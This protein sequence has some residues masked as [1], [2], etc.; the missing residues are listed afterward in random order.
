MNIPHLLLQFD[1]V[2]WQHYHSL[3]SRSY[4]DDPSSSTA[5]QHASLKCGLI[6][7]LVCSCRKY[8]VLSCC[9]TGLTFHQAAQPYSYTFDPS[10]ATL[11]QLSDDPYL[12]FL[13]EATMA[14]V[15]AEGA[16]T[17]EVLRIAS[18]LAP[19]SLEGFYPPFHWF[20]QQMHDLAESIDP[21]V[22]PVGAREAYFHA[23]TYNRNSV[24]TLLG[25]VNDP[26]LYDV[27]PPMQDEFAKA[28]ALLK[29]APGLPL[30]I[31]ATNSSIGAFEIPAYFFKASA[32]NSSLPTFI[33][34]TGYDGPMQDLYHFSCSEIL[35]RGVNC[36]T[37][38]GP[39]QA[40]P[41]R[42]GHPF[43][44]D[45]WSVV[46]PIVDYLHTRPDV[47]TDKIVLLGDSFGGLLAPL[48]ASKEH[49]LSAMVLLDGY[50]NFRQSLIEQFPDQLITLYNQSK[51]AE[52]N[53]TVLE[54]LASPDVPTSLKY[55]WEYTFWSLMSE[56]PY[57]AWTR[58]GDF[59][60]GP[61]TATEI[62]DLPVFVAKGQVSYSPLLSFLS[63]LLSG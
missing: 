58:L 62:G 3:H 36:L 26:R 48:A 34:G 9:S 7:G 13:L 38:E 37:Y 15:I 45:W 6:R 61:A 47:D 57:R 12:A 24:I 10:N 51:A 49:R 25:N 30:N 20:A 23:S 55:L 17:A 43:I 53:H 63:P 2:S 50:P 28:I 5:T 8:R 33:V 44:T 56:D 54:A 16:S 19:G 27:W 46:T 42:A 1:S 41:R 40:T 39:G 29:P 11:Y 59:S 60:W 21:N 22:D 52:F 31:T 18:Q 32:S 4:G 35:K 14:T